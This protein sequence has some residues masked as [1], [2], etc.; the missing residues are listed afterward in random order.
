MQRYSDDAVRN[1]LSCR[2]SNSQDK[3][4]CRFILKQE[5][6]ISPFY[7]ESLPS[8]VR[9]ENMKNNMESVEDDE[10]DEDDGLYVLFFSQTHPIVFK[11]TLTSLFPHKED[12][13]AMSPPTRGVGS[14]ENRPEGR[15]CSA[16]EQR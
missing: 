11:Q 7:F 13:V 3:L 12:F 9:M 2:S 4:H 1:N 14:L 10:D 16:V 6:N 15:T 5:I 8:L